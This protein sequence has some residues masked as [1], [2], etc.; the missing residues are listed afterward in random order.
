MFLPYSV[1][2][3]RVAW[4]VVSFMSKVF[5][6]LFTIKFE[7]TQLFLL[8]AFYADFSKS[9]AGHLCWQRHHNRKL[10]L[11]REQGEQEP[12]LLSSVAD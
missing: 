5:R 4:L 6:H 7:Q 3:L 1:V 11:E 9:R 8:G 10:C 2:F 12:R